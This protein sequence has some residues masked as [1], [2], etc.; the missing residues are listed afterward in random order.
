M[1]RGRR[2]LAGVLVAFVGLFVVLSAA[3][4]PLL[5]LIAAGLVVEDRLEY[6]DAI[7]VVAGGTPSREAVAA[8]LFRQGWAPRVVISRPA[9]TNS[10]GQL[11]ALGVRLLDLQGEARLVLEK[12]G[13]PPDRI[14][15]VQEAA[16]TTERELDLVHK[17]AR[18]QGYRRVILVTSPEHTRRVKVVWTRENRSRAIEDI[19]VPARDSDLD[20]DDWWRKRRSAETVLHEYLGL[21]A[22]YLGISRLMN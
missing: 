16:R 12:Y 18:A 8:E 9:T 5:G 21:A 15:P 14:V 1:T 22:I 19:V 13:V 4:R 20:L 10:I 17:L 11:T 3:H 2:S 6:A 7:V